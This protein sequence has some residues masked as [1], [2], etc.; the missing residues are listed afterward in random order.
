MTKVPSS[1]KSAQAR[2]K[3]LSSKG[4]V[5]RAKATT[6]AQRSEIARKGGTVTYLEHGPEL[7]RKL[8]R[9]RWNAMP[10]SEKEK[11]R[12][13]LRKANLDRHRRNVSKRSSKS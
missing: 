11:V 6:A 7:Y 5:A 9:D 12:E 13:L 8:Q 4:G 10:E 2:R 3:K 1:N